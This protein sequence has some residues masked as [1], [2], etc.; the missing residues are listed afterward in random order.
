MW[1]E[2]GLTLSRRHKGVNID[3]L[4]STWRWRR[5]CRDT[6]ARRL[7][8]RVSFFARQSC[9]A[10]SS[11]SSSSFCWF[12]RDG[13]C[14]LRRVQPVTGTFLPVSF[15]QSNASFPSPPLVCF[16]SFFCW[17]PRSLPPYIHINL[18]SP[19]P[20]PFVHL[21]YDHRDRVC[22]NAC[23][24]SGSLGRLQMFSYHVRN[25]QKSGFTHLLTDYYNLQLRNPLEK[26]MP[27]VYIFYSNLSLSLLS[28]NLISAAF[29]STSL[30]F[31]WLP[32]F[33]R[34]L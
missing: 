33:R 25:R 34:C 18:L 8:S 10:S 22:K 27:A 12:T 20:L 2:R 5:R 19:S 16:R 1:C 17:Y 15:A 28:T 14:V 26:G 9:P 24:A 3:R 30:K 21:P 32:Q 6:L 4:E 11:S 7:Y 13:C 31:L 29:V 23:P